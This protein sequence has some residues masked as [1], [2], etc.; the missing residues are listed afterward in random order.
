VN[1]NDRENIFLELV[2]GD[3][4]NAEERDHNTILP[5]EGLV[6][7]CFKSREIVEIRDVPDNYFKISSGL[8][9]QKPGYLLLLPIK[10]DTDI[11]GVIEM[12]SFKD[13]ESYK[14]HFIEKLAEMMVPI[15]S[16][17]KASMLVEEMFAKT[18]EQSEELQ[19]QEEELRQN[20]EEMR[21]TQEE[22]ERAKL[23]LEEQIEALKKENL[24][25][26]SKPSNK[27]KH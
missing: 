19:A 2:A 15:I 13:I 8:G 18:R 26:Q 7:A 6:G 5:G 10:F 17:F 22:S 3:I 21:A 11:E 4:V 14:I 23:K 1:N 16:S 24:K 12:A 27:K 20:M 9:A 25:L